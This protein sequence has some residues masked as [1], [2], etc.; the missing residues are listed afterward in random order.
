MAR[1]SLDEARDI[2]DVEEDERRPPQEGDAE[3]SDAADLG[4]TSEHSTSHAGTRGEPKGKRAAGGPPRKEPLNPEEHELEERYLEG[5]TQ[6]TTQRE[7]EAEGE[8][9]R[10][11]EEALK[12]DYPDGAEEDRDKARRARERLAAGEKPGQADTD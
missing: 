6:D 4:G 1:S 5:A 12:T 3:R 10:P 8:P 9:D 11:K 7:G 2:E